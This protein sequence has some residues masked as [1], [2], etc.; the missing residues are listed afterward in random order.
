[1]SKNCCG[2]KG[3]LPICGAVPF[4]SFRGICLG[5]Q[6]KRPARPQVPPGGNVLKKVFHSPQPPAPQ[7]GSYRWRDKGEDAV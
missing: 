4:V 3:T 2:A 6:S 5:S 1:M 7:R